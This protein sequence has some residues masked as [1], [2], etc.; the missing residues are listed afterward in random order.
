[1]LI[2]LIFYDDRIITDSSFLKYRLKNK[3]FVSV[4]G[5][6]WSPGISGEKMDI[7]PTPQWNVGDFSTNTFLN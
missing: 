1:M 4:K 5:A 7:H 3:L 2:F 6:K